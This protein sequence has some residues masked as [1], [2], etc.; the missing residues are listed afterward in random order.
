MVPNFNFDFSSEYRSAILSNTVTNPVNNSV[1]N[2]SSDVTSSVSPT[3]SAVTNVTNI[4]QT[5]PNDPDEDEFGD[6]EEA[7]PVAVSP[8]N[9]PSPFV[10]NTSHQNP[11]VNS[12]LPEN[13]NI[14]TFSS[15]EVSSN[16][17]SSRLVFTNITDQSKTFSVNWPM[18]MEINTQHLK[19][20]Q[21][22]LTNQ[23]L[24]LHSNPFLLNQS[25]VSL[26][27]RQLS[28]SAAWIP[29]RHKILNP[30]QNHWQR[31]SVYPRWEFLFTLWVIIYESSFMSHLD[32]EI[33]KTRCSRWKYR[34]RRWFWRFRRSQT[35]ISNSKISFN[36]NSDPNP[37]FSPKIR[38]GQSCKGVE[39]SKT[40][41]N[42]FRFIIWTRF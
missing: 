6:F 1:T 23:N 35:R 8:T 13:P 37:E 17:N 29:S 15:A 12:F 2:T 42:Q 41:W 3:S 24:Y 18:R 31:L 5:S 38:F 28:Q 9:N 4:E 40:N 26:I 11:V 39:W 20:Y 10:T 19:N 7:A 34:R 32:F 22:I 33:F 16:E 25:T 21:L 14:Q 36:L 30:I 27:L